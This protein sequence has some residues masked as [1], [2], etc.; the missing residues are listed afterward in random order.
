MRELRVPVLAERGATA[1]DALESRLFLRTVSEDDG[2][3]LSTDEGRDGVTRPE[4]LY[5][6]PVEGV[7]RVLGDECPGGDRDARPC[8]STRGVSDTLRRPW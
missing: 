6:D 7:R 3:L 4:A 8:T 1:S 5:G 2:R